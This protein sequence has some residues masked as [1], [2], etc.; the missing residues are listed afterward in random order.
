MVADYDIVQAV[1][2]TKNKASVY[3]ENF[4]RMKKYVD[5]S[6]EELTT[7]T[8][9]TLSVYQTVN[10]LATSGTITL[11]DNSVNSI[12]PQGDVSFVLP[13]ITG[14]EVGKFHQILVQMNLEDL[15]DIDLGA[16]WSFNNQALLINAVGKYNIIYEYDGENWVC[17]VLTRAEDA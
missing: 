10:T 2:G 6:V 13:S 14:E 5:D 15:Y 3:N 9:N 17:G 12:I 7:E 16:N 4:N 1:A 11:T 8:Q